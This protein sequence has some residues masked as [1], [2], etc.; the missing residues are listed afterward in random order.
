MTILI[1]VLLG[2]GRS[3]EMAGDRRDA[4]PAFDP[5]GDHAQRSVADRAGAA[6]APTGPPR[7]PPEASKNGNDRGAFVDLGLEARIGSVIGVGLRLQ[8]GQRNET[9]PEGVGARPEPLLMGLSGAP[10]PRRSHAERRAPEAAEG[11]RAAEIVGAHRAAP[12]GRGGLQLAGPLARPDRPRTAHIPGQEPVAPRLADEQRQNGGERSAGRQAPVAAGSGIDAPVQSGVAG[13]VAAGQAG[14][15]PPRGGEKTRIAPLTQEAPGTGEPAGGIETDG[16]IPSRPVLPGRPVDPGRTTGAL[17]VLDDAR[18]TLALTLAPRLAPRRTPGGG[19]TLEPIRDAITRAAADASGRADTAR[20]TGARPDIAP[21]QTAS[22][23]RVLDAAWRTTPR[24]FTETAVA[25]E[26]PAPPTVTS[27]V[28]MVGVASANAGPPPDSVRVPALTPATIQAIPPLATR[29][30][31]PAPGTAAD[32]VRSEALRPPA[33]PNESGAAQVAA[34]ADSNPTKMADSPPGRHETVSETERQPSRDGAG[35]A[36]PT[37]FGQERVPDLRSAAQIEPRTI[38]AAQSRSDTAVA[39]AAV[40]THQMSAAVP[41]PM[42]A[43]PAGQGGAPSAGIGVADVS[44][45]PA[46]LSEQRSAGPNAG[47]VGPAAGDFFGASGSGVT[48]AGASGLGAAPLPLYNPFLARRTERRPP[49]RTSG[50]PQRGNGLWAIL[51]VLR[52]RRNRRGGAPLETDLP[53]ETAPSERAWLATLIARR[54]RLG[55]GVEKGPG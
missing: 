4:G 2:L 39:S 23:A 36:A 19:P 41:A 43:A 1:G 54:R 24:P 51:R 50:A 45:P 27:A 30:P 12:A 5:S 16:A 17:P 37:P 6:A 11:L 35:L 8:L 18:A 9:G 49:S 44:R 42:P 10:A 40:A 3:P 33:V 26:R 38:V 20:A 21:V 28:A 25:G 14:A 34:Q 22:G 29:P 53:E 55:I 15:G 47:S 46:G 13:V 32:A 7:V 31:A 52:W 48:P